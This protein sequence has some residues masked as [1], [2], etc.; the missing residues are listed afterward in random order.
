[1]EGKK[2][3]T[4]KTIKHLLKHPFAFCFLVKHDFLKHD[5]LKHYLDL[6][7]ILLKHQ[8]LGQRVTVIDFEI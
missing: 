5:L 8:W 6:A 3:L 2:W 4:C 7:A 1:L